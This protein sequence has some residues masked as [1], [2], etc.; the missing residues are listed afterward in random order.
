MLGVTRSYLEGLVVVEVISICARGGCD[1][2]VTIPQGELQVITDA[3]VV[4]QRTRGCRSGD[5]PSF[6]QLHPDESILP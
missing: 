1:W 2:L 6:S 5:H 3:P 4:S